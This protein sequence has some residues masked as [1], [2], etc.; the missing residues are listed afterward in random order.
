MTEKAIYKKINNEL[1]Q[2]FIHEN[3]S[4]PSGWTD[5][6][7]SLDIP[8]QYSDIDILKKENEEL[9][10]RLDAA[11]MTALETLD[12]MF[13]LEMKLEGGEAK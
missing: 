4:I 7:D 11:E 12:M 2:Q 1:H 3:E 5:N 6:L 9:K 8:V 13:N 10:M